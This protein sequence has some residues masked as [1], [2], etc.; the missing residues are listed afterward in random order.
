MID[1]FRVRKNGGCCTVCSDPRGFDDDDDDD[2]DL[3][4]LGLEAPFC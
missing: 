1:G 3:E 2:D 4:W